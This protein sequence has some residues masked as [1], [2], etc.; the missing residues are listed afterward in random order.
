M[1]SIIFAGISGS[2][3]NSNSQTYSLSTPL[4]Q[5][6]LTSSGSDLDYDDVNKPKTEKT[7]QDAYS[8]EE[9]LMENNI[10]L[11][12][13]ECLSEKSSQPYTTSL[14]NLPFG[15]YSIASDLN[16]ELE[17]EVFEAVIRNQ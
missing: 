16:D 2:L 8:F 9:I 14:D 4:L 17:V 12:S 7:H 3:A 5:K 1:L 13:N 15:K 6:N 10:S 11:S